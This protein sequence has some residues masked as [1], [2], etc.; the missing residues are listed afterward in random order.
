MA[1][2]PLFD[3]GHTGVNDFDGISIE[4]FSAVYDS[5]E[6]LRLKFGEKFALCW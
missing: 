3:V 4:Y 1:V 2:N 5:Y 6:I